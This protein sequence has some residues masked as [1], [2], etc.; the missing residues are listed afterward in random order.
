M[1]S[2]VISI[3]TAFAVVDTVTWGQ[4]SRLTWGMVTNMIIVASS[5]MM[6][7]SKAVNDAE[8]GETA[9]E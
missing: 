7:E 9:N 1:Y 6:A 4:H 2:R 3:A 5:V 8:K